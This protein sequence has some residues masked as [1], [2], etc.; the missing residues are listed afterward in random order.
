MSRK[1]F[2]TRTTQD[3][4]TVENLIEFLTAYGNNVE[5]LGFSSE[6][7][8]YSKISEVSLHRTLEGIFVVLRFDDSMVGEL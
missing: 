2:I 1:K 4:N 3:I 6:S 7:G 8:K 5:V